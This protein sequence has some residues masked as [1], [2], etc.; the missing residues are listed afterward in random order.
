M[1]NRQRDRGCRCCSTQ[2]GAVALFAFTAVL[3]SGCCAL[4][5]RGTAFGRLEGIVVFSESIQPSCISPRETHPARQD[6]YGGLLFITGREVY[7]DHLNKGIPNR[8][9]YVDVV[10]DEGNVVDSSPLSKE[11]RVTFA[12]NL[13]DSKGFFS[14]QV[15]SYTAGT[16]YL[17]ARYADKIGVGDSY[18]MKLIFSK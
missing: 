4:R 6:A 3:M 16:Y 18:S 1:K 7:A 13:T 5:T 11:P 9:V 8:K 17:H 2:I 15:A 12:E 10:D 14:V